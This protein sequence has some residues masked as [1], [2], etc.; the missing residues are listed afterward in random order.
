MT[1]SVIII[2]A[3]GHARVLISSLNILGRRLE[4]VLH[5][6]TKIAGQF[7][8]GIPIIGDDDEILRFDPLYVQLVN[9]VGSTSS[10]Y[11][12]R[13]IFLRFKS[14]GYSFASVIHPSAQIMPHVRLE[15]G[16]QIM[17]GAILQTGCVIGADAI[18]NTGA[19]LDHD[20]VVGDHVHIAPGA[21]LSGNVRV[22]AMAHVGT[23]A[24]VIQGVR[25]GS[26]ATIG[27]GA[28]VTG[29]IPENMIACGVPAR[30]RN[31]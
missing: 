24:T 21:T 27:A 15:E 4:G 3:G 30:T 14:M 20:C 9:G 31:S 6:D 28:V 16:V 2:G 19:I 5:P 18:I 23:S 26:G 10:S 8:A 17:A 11:K 22:G 1:S 13:E 12:R 7:V 25:I 29:D